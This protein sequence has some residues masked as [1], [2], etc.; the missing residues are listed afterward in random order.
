M[1]LSDP[2]PPSTPVALYPADACGPV[3]MPRDGWG[4][5]STNARSAS[6]YCRTCARLPAI[7]CWPVQPEAEVPGRPV[8]TLSE[9]CAVYKVLEGVSDLQNRI[10]RCVGF[11][12]AHGSSE[13]VPLCPHV[14]GL[15]GRPPVVQGQLRRGTSGHNDCVLEGG[16]VCAAG[17]AVHGGLEGHWRRPEMHSEGGSPGGGLHSEVGTPQLRTGDGHADV[18]VVPVV[19]QGGQALPQLP[20]VGRVGIEEGPQ[21][22]RGRGKHLWQGLAHLL[23]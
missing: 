2:R 17:G 7:V 12:P 13:G 14:E 6:Q 11:R 19:H 5:R 20:L 23:L 18:A 3:V 9:Q 8:E 1:S 10:W 16:A 21:V 22:Q 4:W 15:P